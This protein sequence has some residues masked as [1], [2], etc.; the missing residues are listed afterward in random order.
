MSNKLITT[1][2]SLGIAL[3]TGTVSLSTP[4]HASTW[5]RGMPKALRGTWRAPHDKIFHS[6]IVNGANYSRVYSNDPGFLN[7]TK[8][9]YLGNHY[10]KVSGYEPIYSKSTEVRYFKWVN[11]HYIKTNNQWSKHY[12]ITWRK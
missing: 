9:R 7:R 6:T 10:Y 4:V 11:R 5:H 2:L 8:Y 12:W 3:L 1:T